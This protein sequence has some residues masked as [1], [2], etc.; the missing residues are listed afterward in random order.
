M[1]PR[2][3]RELAD[4]VAK[5][6]SII[7]EKSW[8][9][10]KVHSDWKKGNITTIFKKEGKEDPGNCKPVSLSSVLGKTMEQILWKKY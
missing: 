2:I 1:H 10:G 3:L 9:S 4:G 8:Q 7:R 5:L 6:L